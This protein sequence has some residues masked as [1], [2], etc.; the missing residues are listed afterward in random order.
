[1]LI[2]CLTVI[3]FNLRKIKSG[4]KCPTFPIFALGGA[5]YG[6][7]YIRRS[8]GISSFLKYTAACSYSLEHK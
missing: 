1:M 7:I 3:F 2:F 4:V 6:I 5:T 8:C